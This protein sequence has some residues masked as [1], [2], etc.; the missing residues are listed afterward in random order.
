VSE[1]D[2]TLPERPDAPTRPAEAPTI[3]RANRPLSDDARKLGRYVLLDLLGMGGM[4]EVYAAFDPTLDRKVA[5][6]LLFPGLEQNAREQ[7]LGEARALARLTHPNVVA[8]H[9]VGEENGRAYLALE[10]A[11]GQTLEKWL[12]E[13]PRGWREVIDVF[14]EAGRGLHAAHLAGLVHRDFKPSNVMIRQDGRVQLLDFGIARATVVRPPAS[15]V[16]GLTNVAGT[17]GFMSPEQLTG[18]RL[19][20]RSDQFSFCA[21]LHEALYGALPFGNT[22]DEAQMVRIREQRFAMGVP[23]ADLPRRLLPLVRRGLANAPERRFASMGELLRQLKFRLPADRR[24]L[25][26]IALL[27]VIASGS[28]GLAVLK[29][30]RLACSP[31]QAEIAEHWKQQRA[32][33]AQKLGADPEG[34]LLQLD[35]WLGTLTSASDKVCSDFAAGKPGERLLREQQC[36]SD[37]QREFLQA[38][39][40]ILDNQAEARQLLE[41]AAPPEACLSSDVAVAF[42]VYLRLGPAR[43]AVSAATHA[44][45]TG[46]WLGGLRLCDQADREAKRLGS[47]EL[48]SAALRLKGLMFER[49]GEP[50]LAEATLHEAA[51]VAEGSTD[52]SRAAAWLSLARVV[53]VRGG[54]PAAGAVWARYAR[55]QAERFPQRKELNASLEL[56][57]QRLAPGPDSAEKLDFLAAQLGPAHPLFPVVLAER[58]RQSKTAAELSAEYGRALDAMAAHDPSLPTLLGV[59]DALDGLPAHPAEGKRLLEVSERTL[60]KDPAAALARLAVARVA[61][62]AGAV[63][64]AREVAARVVVETER[65]PALRAVNELAQLELG[66]AQL[67]LGNVADAMGPLVAAKAAID[68]RQELDGLAPGR[69]ARADFWEALA[70]VRARKPDAAVRLRAAIAAAEHAGVERVAVAAAAQE[71]EKKRGR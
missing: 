65:D 33:A 17:P 47:P 30:R 52:E 31:K 42:D 62:E 9:E 6:K 24:M 16:G 60:A 13:K 2:S 53:G 63:E 50:K 22:A 46:D 37:R 71:A 36:L 55:A 57:G 38:S 4:G 48:R 12:K 5:L 32:T 20:A 1:P 43:N 41:E 44:W 10:Y 29:P 8:V 45:L 21:A 35:A 15:A 34:M 66:V 7:M 40:A 51:L 23:R 68:S 26:L 49:L 64:A 14:L 11:D 19:D 58:A 27:A 28:L 3:P 67:Q 59:S 61:R 70:E 25:A 54:E 69:A 56:L 39:A 18:E